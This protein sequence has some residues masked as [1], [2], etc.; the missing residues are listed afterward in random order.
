METT[1]RTLTK[2][3][4]KCGSAPDCE[5]AHCLHYHNHLV[6][7]GEIYGLPTDAC[8]VAGWC[9]IIHRNVHCVPVYAKNEE[10]L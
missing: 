7:R 6:S 2:I 1:S 8:V 3:G 4:N 10:A 9:S 5:R